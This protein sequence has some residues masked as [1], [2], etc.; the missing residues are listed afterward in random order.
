M[1]GSSSTTRTVSLALAEML[2]RS[3]SETGRTTLEQ[4]K[5]ALTVVPTPGSEDRVTAPP[6]LVTMP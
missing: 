4:G 2:G 6:A 1:L 5:W 3:S